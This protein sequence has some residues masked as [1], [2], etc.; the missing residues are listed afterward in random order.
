MNAANGMTAS[1]LLVEDEVLVR[2]FAADVLAE[3]GGF[4]VLETANA[5]EA[6]LVLESRRDVRVL[7]TD[8]D[9]PGSI[10]GYA[11]ARLVARRWPSIRI[12]VSSGKT[13]PAAGD[14]PAHAR[15]LPKPYSPATLLKLV[16]DMLEDAS[17]TSPPEMQDPAVIQ[18]AP[19]LPVAI[20]LHQPHFGIGV[21]GGLGQCLPEADQ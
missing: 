15:F 1:I 16:S 14:L 7:F 13:G 5:D 12:I 21:T 18:G 6:M 11:L 19:V 10:N 2:L 8:V 17:A 4:E 3:D 20:K 9:M